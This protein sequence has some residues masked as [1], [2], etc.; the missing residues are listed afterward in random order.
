MDHSVSFLFL[1][2]F[3]AAATGCDCRWDKD[4]DYPSKYPP[5]IMDL[6][7]WTSVLP[8]MEG[9]LRIVT[10]PEGAELVLACPETVIDELN[11]EVVQATCLGDTTLTV[12]GEDYSLSELGCAKRPRE[13]LMKDLGSCGGSIGTEHAIGFDVVGYDF[14]ELVRVCFDPEEEANLYSTHTIRGAY[15]AASDSNPDRPSFK[16]DSGFYSVSVSTCYEQ[17]TQI[18]LMEDILGDSS[19]IDVNSNL[20]FARGHLAPDA[21]FVTEQ[22]RD[23]TYYYINVAPQWQTFNNGNWKMLEFDVRELSSVRGSDLTVWTGTWKVLEM[24]DINNNGVDIYLGLSEGE[25]VVP[26]PAVMWKVVYDP[27]TNEGAAVV[28]VNYPYLT[29]FPDTICGS[30]SFCSELLWLSFNQENLESGAMYCCTVQELLDAVPYAP[31]LG[32]ADILTE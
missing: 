3:V 10:V 20:Y 25:S 8:K 23:A 15:E 30:E 31:D 14:Y 19:V 27:A 11:Q 18:A 9:D 29:S 4:A 5:L 12:D 24:D 17:K 13:T 28:G 7:S 26:A 16:S 32:D 1:L 2:A 6:E 22:E 21:D